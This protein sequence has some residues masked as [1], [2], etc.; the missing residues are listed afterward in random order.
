MKILPHAAPAPVAV[1]FLFPAIGLWLALA[2]PA[3]TQAKMIAAAEAAMPDAAAL[4]KAIGE[5]PAPKDES[6]WWCR[7]TLGIR[8]PFAVTGDAVAYYEK[9][10][11]GWRKQEL[12]RYMEPSSSLD[13]Q[14]SAAFHPEFEHD[15]RKFKDVHVVTLKLSFSQRFAA[16]GT[17][18]MEFQKE[19]TVV[20]DAAGKVL[21]ITGDGATEAMVMAI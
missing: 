9:L 4:R 8:I 1:R 12:E 6:Q 13:Y 14:A 15:G 11:E 17:E 21:A 18:G 2:G 5:G 10:V 3:A 7:E 16:T 20:L 19:R